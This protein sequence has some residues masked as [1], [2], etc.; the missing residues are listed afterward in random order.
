[1]LGFVSPPAS[2][3]GE[4][5]RVSFRGGFFKNKIF[6]LIAIYT[7]HP[8]PFFSCRKILFYFKSWGRN[9]R[10][11]TAAKS[12]RNLTNPIEGWLIM[13]AIFPSL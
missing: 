2:A 11:E 7:F 12:N 13:K 1:M 5:H 3:T 9:L 4:E 8:S 6:A 10:L